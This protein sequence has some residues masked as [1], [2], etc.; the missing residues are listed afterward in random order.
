MET[1][2]RIGTEYERACIDREMKREKLHLIAAAAL[3]FFGAVGPGFT[4]LFFMKM[5]AIAVIS[6]V[7]SICTA[8]CWTA[9]Y[10]LL[11][12]G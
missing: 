11:G 9:A 12:R 7:S 1:I 8:A 10:K 6:T 2:R 3:L 5:Q 4:F